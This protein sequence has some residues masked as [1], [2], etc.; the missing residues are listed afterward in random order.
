MLGRS[1]AEALG[2]SWVGRRL[3]AWADAGLKLGRSWRRAAGFS[4]HQQGGMYRN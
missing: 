2:R 1:W 3:G 4:Y